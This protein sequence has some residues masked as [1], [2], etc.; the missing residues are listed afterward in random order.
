MSKKASFNHR[1]RADWIL[2]QEPPCW[3]VHSSDS[4][5]F[6]QYYFCPLSCFVITFSIIKRLH[7]YSSHL[8][9]RYITVF[10]KRSP[11]CTYT[12][13]LDVRFIVERSAEMCGFQWAGES[14]RHIKLTDKQI[15][16]D[17][18]IPTIA[19]RVASGAEFLIWHTFRFYHC[20]IWVVG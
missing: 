20:H 9:G 12:N 18:G 19:P 13:L 4:A 6:H 7:R 17:I 8:Y 15:S 11:L 10:I 5:D 16:S 3:D 14:I 1:F 2:K